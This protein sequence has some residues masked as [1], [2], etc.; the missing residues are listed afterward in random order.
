VDLF[1]TPTSGGRT[2]E[3]HDCGF[4]DR[5][6]LLH[7]LIPTASDPDARHSLDPSG[8]DS[9]DRMQIGQ[10]WKLLHHPE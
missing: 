8:A 3:L 7:R 1:G 2:G 5:A 4:M 6:Q 9:G 10:K